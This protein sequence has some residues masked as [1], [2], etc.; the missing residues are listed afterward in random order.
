MTLAAKP[1]TM[2]ANMLRQTA[3][4]RRP[5]VFDGLVRKADITQAPG[6][7]RI[8]TTP[9]SGRTGECE[10]VSKIDSTTTMDSQ[11]PVITG[12]LSVSDDGFFK[13]VRDPLTIPALGERALTRCSESGSDR[14]RDEAFPFRTKNDAARFPCAV[15]VMCQDAV[16][17]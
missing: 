1:I 14:G 3:R 4:T 2:I 9:G 17:W 11:S 12:Y 13:S 5:E 15:E 6:S 16:E 8:V 10:W 7:K